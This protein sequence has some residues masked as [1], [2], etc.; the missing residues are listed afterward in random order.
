[1]K[2]TTMIFLVLLL[3]VGLMLPATAMAAKKGKKSK[4]SKNKSPSG[5]NVRMFDIA[6]DFGLPVFGLMPFGK[7]TDNDNDVEVDLSGQG[8]V[9]FPYMGLHFTLY[10]STEWYIQL[11][12]G[13]LHHSGDMEFT[14]D[15]V[16]QID[17][18]KEDWTMNG[19]RLDAGIGKIFGKFGRVRPKAGAGLGIWRLSFT[20]DTDEYDSK[21]FIGWTVGPYGLVGVDADVI[22]QRKFD[23]FAG[24]N[25]RTDILYTIGP[26]KWEGSGDKEVTML[27]WPWSIYL[28]AGLR[29]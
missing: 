26:L 20:P 8:T 9:S 19:L 25:L 17:G 29:F 10:P 28:S 22:R 5:T 3:A 23:I 13:Y 18:D 15:D 2:R 16:K 12:L 1:M 14:S 7:V 24:I 4:G 11:G 6:A 21:S 27:Y